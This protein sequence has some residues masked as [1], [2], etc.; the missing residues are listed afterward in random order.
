MKIINETGNLNSWFSL[1]IGLIGCVLMFGSLYFWKQLNYYIVIFGLILSMVL[2]G[3][4]S[5]ALKSS[6]LDLRAFTADPI[7]W[8]KAKA[9]YKK[10]ADAEG[11]T[12]K[13]AEGDKLKTPASPQHPR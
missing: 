12:D 9:S 10:E 8:R 5:I 11:K 6:T 13:L 1:L 2:G 7:G 3:F 4:A